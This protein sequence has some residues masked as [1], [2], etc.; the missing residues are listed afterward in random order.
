M[1]ISQQ[2]H[3]APISST[4]NILVLGGTQFS[5]RAF[6]ELAVQSGHHIT[7]LHRSPQDPGLPYPVRRL[8]GDRDPQKGDGLDRI[9][10]LLNAGE[11]FDAVVD[12][13]GYTPRV[14]KA[15]CDLLKDACDQYI[16]ISTISVYDKSP[17]SLPLSEDAKK[18]V[19]ANPT[20]EEVTGETYGGLKVLC[21]Q[22][23]VDAFPNTHCIPRPCVI[24]GPND[25]TDRVT[26]WTRV[27][28]T[29]DELVI[30]KA[31]AGRASFIDSRDLA[32]FFLHCAVNKTMGIF[33]TTGPQPELSLHEFINRTHSALG[34]KTKLI[35]ADHAWIESQGA[36]RWIDYPMWIA[37]ESQYMHSISSSK[38][39][40]AGL[41]NRPLEDTIRAI[42]AWDVQRGSPVLKA[43]M[44]PDRI[45]SMVESYQSL[46]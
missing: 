40:A 22:V 33:N 8:V 19:L 26:W 6:V 16:F 12:M 42:R 28:S 20:V 30:P 14:T 9:Q 5:G 21:E 35:E 32:A 37:D 2:S 7:L 24:A 1:I 38:A 43:G 31:P 46:A 29:Q 25:P 11:R 13:C 4:M 41:T 18:I 23:V 36:K 10:E 39:L 17:K 3:I 45:K 15:A 44:Q 27:L 34:S